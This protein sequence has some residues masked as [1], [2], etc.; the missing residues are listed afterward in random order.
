MKRALVSG[1]AVLVLTIWAGAQGS[2]KAGS[3]SGTVIKE[4]GDQPLK[5][6]LL[7]LISDN[8]KDGSNYTTETDPDGHF[9]FDQIQPG[10]YRLLLEKS[11][12]RAINARGHEIDGPLLTVQLG[13]QI[14]GVLYQMLPTAVV[15]GKV[16][17]EDGDPMPGYGVTLLRLKRGKTGQPELAGEERTNDL[18][19]YRFS[20][21]FPGRYFVAV[22]PP[23]D[24][25]NFAHI[26]GEPESTPQP[27]TSYLTT[28]YPGTNDGT[29]ASPIDVR[30]GDELPINLTM[31][32]SRSFR[33]RGIVTGIPANQKP[34]VQL[35]SRGVIQ[36]MNG[37]DVAADGQFQIRGVAPGSYLVTVFAGAEGQTLS[38][39][40]SISV[41]AAD[42]EGV[43][44]VP[45]RSFSMYGQ[46]RFE[47]RP[48][49]E[50][51]RCV[52]S[53]RSAADSDDGGVATL[54]PGGTS[55][56]QL[57][58]FGKFTWSEMTPGTYVAQFG[59]D[60]NPD[61]FLKSVTVNGQDATAGF[62]VSGPSMIE[63]VV[64]SQG[65]RLEGVVME[66]D[67][68]AENATVV[69]VPEE[70]FRKLHERFGTASSDQHGRF[71]IRGLA[72]GSYT[73]F[74]WQ[75]VDEG[76]YFDADFLKSQESN[77]IGIK[78]QEGAR[79]TLQLELAPVPAE[80]Q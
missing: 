34:M 17:D 42:V 4:P 45:L 24:I 37:A 8:Q 44:L 71:T 49:R 74:A 7:H 31:I 50:I 1:L 70:K 25:R 40:Q 28:Y 72:P 77:G 52:A 9:L 79:Q 18:G 73:V 48:A 6:V 3:I 67:K 58:L 55:A 54:L 32:P 35:M 51:N 30:A 60:G 43:K 69:A 65:A 57:D 59:G 16:V 68:P 19:Q 38:A 21:L 56:A 46:V 12:F 10:R 61:T 5:K 22:V 62:K 23:P 26:K 75:D 13:Q 14:S 80:W 2:P 36:T 53:V 41:V 66:A 39:R 20:G 64:T 63:M 33:I 27:D 76:L 47:G 78:L 29:Q 11:G 15:T